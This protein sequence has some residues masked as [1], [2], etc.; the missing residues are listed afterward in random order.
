MKKVRI[1]ALILILLLIAASKFFPDFLVM[2]IFEEPYL[3]M[4]TI[5]A[6]LAI[7]SIAALPWLTSAGLRRGGTIYFL[8]LK[9]VTYLAT[10]LALT[11]PFVGRLLATNWSYSF[12]NAVQ[13][14][15]GSAEAGYLFWRFTGL[16]VLLPLIVFILIW[17]QYLVKKL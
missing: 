1:T 3:P 6:W 13:G 8:I 12:S 14:F 9:Y 17:G 16:I 7:L 4:G 5:V 11:W 2:A 10:G 15:A